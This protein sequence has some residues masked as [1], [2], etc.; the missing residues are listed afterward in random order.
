MK[1]KLE[2]QK[3]AL[4]YWLCRLETLLSDGYAEGSG[5]VIVAKNNIRDLKRKG[6]KAA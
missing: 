5:V 1:S 3:N 6:I 2:R 4:A